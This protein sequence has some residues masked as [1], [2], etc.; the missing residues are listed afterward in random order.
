M[1]DDQAAEDA[2]EAAAVPEESRA[3]MTVL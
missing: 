1:A 3:V 2:A